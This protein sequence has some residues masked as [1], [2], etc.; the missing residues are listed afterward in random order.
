MNFL[1]CFFV[2]LIY[3]DV[4]LVSE[5]MSDTKSVNGDDVGNINDLHDVDWDHMAVPVL[6]DCPH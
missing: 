3:L 2:S 4:I 5:D 6:L 1:T